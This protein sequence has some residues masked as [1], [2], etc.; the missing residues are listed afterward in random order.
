MTHI[1]ENEL[2]AT[3]AY[4]YKAIKGLEEVIVES[5]YKDRARR[6]LTVNLLD[7]SQCRAM[8]NTE[9]IE[10]IKN[11]PRIDGAVITMR[12]GVELLVS[13]S[14]DSLDDLLMGI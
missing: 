13:D 7:A 9:R 11:H 4:I 14:L 8:I 10:M 5:S 12:S 6:F 3:V 1:Y 2:N